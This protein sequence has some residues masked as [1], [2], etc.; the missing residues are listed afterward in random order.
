MVPV[1]KLKVPVATKFV[2]EALASWIFVPVAES[3][4]SVEMN[5]ESELKI[6]ANKLVV[7]ASVIDAKFE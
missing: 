2:V 5:A 4:I 3:N 7:V 1:A 6:A